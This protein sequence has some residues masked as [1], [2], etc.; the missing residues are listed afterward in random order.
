MH[1]W[2]AQVWKQKYEFAK[3]ENA[4]MEN[5]GATLRR[6]ENTSMKT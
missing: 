3:V 6:V 5:T 2:K 4:S 1:S